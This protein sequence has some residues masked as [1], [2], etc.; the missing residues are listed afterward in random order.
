M[1]YPEWPAGTATLG[2]ATF[3]P[4]AG[5]WTVQATP[6]VLSWI[7]KLFPA[8]ATKS[9]RSSVTF[10]ATWR[11]FVDFSLILHR[12][13]I[14]IASPGAFDL[15]WS[16]AATKR[17]LADK[18][19]RGEISGAAGH[20][21]EFEKVIA[22]TLMPF[23]VDGV[24]FLTNWRRALLGDDMGLGKTVQGLCAVA[25][26]GL[27]P[28]LVCVPSN[29][30]RQWEKVSIPRWL[31]AA[32]NDVFVCRGQS[33][34][35][36]PATASIVLTHYGLLQYWKS[37]LL[38]RRFRAIIW[39]ECQELR[40]WNKNQKWPVAHA[41]A[42]EGADMVIGM[43]GT[44]IYNYADEIWSVLTCIEPGCLG[45]HSM[46]SAQWCDGAFREVANP[47]ALGAYLRREGLFLRRRKLDVLKDLPPKRRMVELIDHDESAAVAV[48]R[49]AVQKKR[50][51]DRTFGDLK[52]RAQL[53]NEA[54]MRLRQ[55]TG[56]AKAPFVAD[57]IAG[58]CEAGEKVIVGVWHHAVR[59]IMAAKLQRFAPVF[60]TGQE[61][62]TQRANSLKLFSDP[63]SATRIVFISNRLAP[64]LDGLQGVSNTVVTA[65]F[66]WSPQ[67][68]GQ[69]E[70]RLHR[71]GQGSAVS[72][73][74]LACDFGSDPILRGIL[75][76]KTCQFVGLMG[77][78]W[79][80]DDE[81]ETD[82]AE[83]RRRLLAV[84]DHLARK[85]A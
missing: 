80:K 22:G 81:A 25:S 44:P 43:S 73:Y 47:A 18:I 23:Q 12:F 26:Q 7:C 63:H 14:R 9:D 52:K 20:A 2:S 4:K 53:E 33:P 54:L 3:D 11:T 59:D 68:H 48:I 16:N 65:E 79:Q 45:E 74:Y 61:T 27:F 5:S 85:V 35:P 49:A 17:A 30:L 62:Q 15:Q 75:G 24:R 28:V 56:I 84:V 67:I 31:P 46:F 64:G 83:L 8:S 58:L 72:S 66:D 37:E 82:R 21:K 70:D 60:I 78:P 32:A 1:T 77:D 39:D 34:R 19:N 41:L 36:I 55:A 42:S 38:K 69:F 29:I 76:V 6:D 51:A 57:F 40:I 71:I 10:R 50:E 13:P